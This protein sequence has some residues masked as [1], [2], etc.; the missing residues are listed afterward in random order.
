MKITVLSVNENVVGLPCYKLLRDRSA[1]LTERRR[2]GGGG[3]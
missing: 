1:D 2:T 3:V